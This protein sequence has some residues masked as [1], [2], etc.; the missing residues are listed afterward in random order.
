[1]ADR[2]LRRRNRRVAVTG[3]GILSPIG[4]GKEENWKSILAGRS[5]TGPVTL[6]DASRLP[7]RIAGEVTDFDPRIHLDGAAPE[8]LSRSI[9]FALAAAAEAIAD[10]GLYLSGDMDTTRIGVNVGSGLGLQSSEEALQT[11]DARQGGS[12]LSPHFMPNLLANMGSA[13]ISIRWKLK[14]PI[15]CTS[16]ACST[17]SHAIGDSFDII[18][19]GA[20]DVMLAGGTEACI[21]ELTMGGFCAMRLLSTRNDDPGTAS[22][23][24][25]AGRDGFVIGEGAGLLVLE[26]MERAKARGARIYAELSGYGLSANSNHMIQPDPDGEGPI[27]C[28]RMALQDAGRE[29]AEVGYINAHGT[30]T[31]PNDWTE[32]MAI[33]KTFGAHADRLA[34][35]ST[36]SMT[37]HMLGATGAAEAI[38]TVLALHHQTLPPTINYKDP[39]PACD[40]DYVPN[41]ARPAELRHAISNSFG[42]GG[43]NAS[44]LF[45]RPETR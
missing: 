40:L 31:G 16:T 34:V 32:T 14:G 12:H 20:A 7:S 18:R 17:G 33:R 4:I 45:S 36:K 35:S 9:Q 42:F 6:F 28:M 3:I 44:L 15:G 43:Q 5:G 13:R 19:R 26:E 41:Q 27:L 29:A 25:D 11:S 23:P 30:A 22:R 21:F 38:Y 1:M 37:G 8:H 24:F 39:D 10:S 2:N